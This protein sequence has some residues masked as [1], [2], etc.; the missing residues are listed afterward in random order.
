MQRLGAEGGITH[1]VVAGRNCTGPV[2]SYLLIG[3]NRTCLK[4]QGENPVERE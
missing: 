4:N 1:G 2:S 3:S